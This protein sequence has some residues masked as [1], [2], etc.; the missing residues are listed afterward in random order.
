VH[1]IEENRDQPFF[2]YLTPSMPHV[3]L[4]AS[5]AFN[6]RSKAGLYGDTIEEIDWA[7][8]EILGCLK[9]N[10][11]DENTLVI[12]T[13]DN[14]PW[15]AMKEHG[16]S[17]LPLRNGKGTTYEGGMRV[18]CIMKMTGMLPGGRTCSAPASALDLLPTFAAMAGIPVKQPVDGVDI[19]P[20]MRGEQVDGARETFLY[21]N[22][23]GQISAIRMGDWKLIFDNPG[24][25]SGKKARRRQGEK[26][27]KPELYNLREDIGEE[28]NLAAAQPE[29]V[30]SMLARARQEDRKVRGQ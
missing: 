19:R 22:K 17:A 27:M 13:S 9:R 18:P 14:G 4:F 1:F 15:L 24:G 28:N 26:G 12:F 25:A 11:L 16:G 10:G 21:Y 7:V 20:L 8:G 30:E 23:P 2:L 29:R 5:E 3:P 6:G